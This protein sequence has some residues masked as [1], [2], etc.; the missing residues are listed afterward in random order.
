MRNREP[1]RIAVKTNYESK[2]NVSVAETDEPGKRSSVKSKLADK[3]KTVEA[4][5]NEMSKEKN[6][7]V[8]RTT[9]LS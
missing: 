4:T 9:E 1:E 6:K 8:S 3:Q 7:T 2:E 5:K